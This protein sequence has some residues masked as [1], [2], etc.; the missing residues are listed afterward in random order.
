MTSSRCSPTTRFLRR[1]MIGGLPLVLGSCMVVAVRPTSTGTLDFSGPAPDVV[2]LGMSGHCAPPC[3]SPTDNYDNL[4]HNGTLDLLADAVSTAGYSVQVSGYTSSVRESFGSPRVSPE[5]RGWPALRRDYV[6]IRREWADDPPRLVLVG[7]SH[8]V[9]WLHQLVRQ[10]PDQPVAALL[11]IDGVCGLWNLDHRA[12]LMEL[13]A[14]LRGQP[15]IAQA[16]QPLPPDERPGG[17][18]VGPKDLVPWNVERGLEVQSFKG[19]LVP[20]PAG[21]Y[22]INVFWDQHANLRPDGSR[23]GLTTGTSV[24]EGHSHLADSGSRGM[25]WLA[26]ELRRLAQEWRGQ[27]SSRAVPGE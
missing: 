12:A 15:D 11:D 10:F 6:R 1:L 26:G 19:A 24:L 5:Q 23:R 22:P 13:S 27:E 3:V 2:I 21:D 25:R 7:H 14:E 17:V 4:G 16:C 20:E 18:R 8:G 9:P